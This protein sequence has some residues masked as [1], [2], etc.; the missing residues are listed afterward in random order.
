MIALL[1]ISGCKESDTLEQR[2]RDALDRLA[3]T[4]ARFQLD[5]S[6]SATIT[7]SSCE[8]G[9]RRGATMW[10]PPPILKELIDV[11]MVSIRLQSQ[12]AN[13]TSQGGMALT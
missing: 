6:F 10:V 1:A 3:Q 12:V 2:T 9:L 7:N 8:I 4:G 13:I 11:S 5:C